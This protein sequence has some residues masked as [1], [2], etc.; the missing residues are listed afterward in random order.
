MAKKSLVAK[1]NRK[2]K[3]KVRGYNRCQRCG[4][5]RAYLRDFG[6]CR[7]C[8]RELASRGELPGVKKA[9]W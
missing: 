5:P 4:R 6:M 3:F 1:A 8:V 2:P 7:I 9:S